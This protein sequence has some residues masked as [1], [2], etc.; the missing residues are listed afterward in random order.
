MTDEPEVNN[1]QPSRRQVLR[2][3]SGLTA[4]GVNSVATSTSVVADPGDQQ[5]NLE[6]GREN[7]RS[8]P[9]VVNGMVF[10]GSWD[11]NLYA[12]DAKTGREQWVFETND[13]IQS[14]PTVVDGTVFFGNN[15]G[16]VYAVDAETGQQQWVFETNWR[17][18]SSPIV[19]NKTIFFGSQDDNLYAIDAETGNQRWIFGTGGAVESSPTVRGETVFVG[20][21]DSNLYAVNNKTGQQQWVFETGDSIRSSPTVSNGL[22]FVG[23]DDTNLY[24]VDAA[25]GEQEWAF[26]TADSPNNNADLKS[27]PTVANGTVFIGSEKSIP[28]IAGGAQ[29]AGSLLYA[30]DVETGA[31]K[32]R[33]K[34][35][36]RVTSSPTVVSKSVFVGCVDANL[37]AINAKTG[38]KEWV[39]ETDGYIY[40]S[41]IVVDGAV[42]FGSADGNLYAVDAG[43]SGSSEGSR[44]RLGTLG[45]HSDWA[46]AHQSLTIAQQEP[47]SEGLIPSVGPLSPPTL[48]VAG[49]GAVGAGMYAWHRSR[50]ASEDADTDIATGTTDTNTS[51]S[52]PDSSTEQTRSME[53]VDQ[54]ITDGNEAIESNKQAYRN[55]EY[56]T[57]VESLSN[58]I[59]YYQA[60]IDRISNPNKIADL[61]ETI[62]DAKAEKRRIESI[63]TVQTAVKEA[64]QTGER[65]FKE[66]IAR[67]AAD[68]QTVARIRFR[69][70]RDAYEEARQTIENS[71]IEMFAEPIEMS[72]EE[73]TT[74]PSIAIEELAAVDDATLNALSA[75]DVE[76]LTDIGDDTDEITPAVLTDLQQNGEISDKEATLLA[77]LSWWYEGDIHVFFSKKEISQRYKKA[78]CGFDQST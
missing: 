38:E 72:F 28:E 2:T 50:Q 71:E 24:A 42:F 52:P 29:E 1:P 43:V 65:N 78:N 17:V 64:L 22:V 15:D 61:E 62:A 5:W 48:I 13:I 53:P 7:D 23:S 14:T 59:E 11:E 8:S 20:S 33:F 26:Q 63:T 40:S 34:T 12:V 27:S 39:F 32:W 35:G 36:D 45:H 76:S 30:I 58:A 31:E 9:T 21:N 41:P 57:A 55:N 4:L 68:N 75:V 46:H 69:Q 67:Y 60:A 44:T 10:V 25:T 56:R 54:L 51:N 74:L 37:Y 66:A 70:A 18:T 47:D 6:V 16:N 3:V 77:V 73:E 19:V 49:G